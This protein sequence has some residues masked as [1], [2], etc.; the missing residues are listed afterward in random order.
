[1]EKA[2]EHI[3]H[4][5]AYIDGIKA[6]RYSTSISS[7]KCKL[8]QWNITTHIR[9][10]KIK[11]YQKYQIPVRGCNKTVNHTMLAEKKMA[12]VKIILSFSL[13]TETEDSI[14]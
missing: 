8:K 14:H 9:M 3:F 6:K 5:R 1:M 12:I 4:Q 7:E 10:A 13:K 11:K 2:H